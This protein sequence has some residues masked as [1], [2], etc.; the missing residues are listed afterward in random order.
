MDKTRTALMTALIAAPKIVTDDRVAIEGVSFTRPATGTWMEAAFMPTDNNTLTLGTGGRD[1]AIGMLQVLLCS[2]RGSSITPGL[3]M[4]KGI[5]D[6]F[7][8][9][10]SLTFQDRT[11]TITRVVTSP[12]YPTN[13]G[14]KT[15][16]T[17]YWRTLIPRS[18]L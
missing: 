3:L 16:V 18:T 14:I 8:A 9:G 13:D 4:L 5:K 10:K 6:R 17:I 1:E 12:S 2:P 15:P 11:V 7:Y